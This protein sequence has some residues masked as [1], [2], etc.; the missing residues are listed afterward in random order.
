MKFDHSY[1]VIPLK[2]IGGEWITLLIKHRRSAFWGFPKGHSDEG[3]TPYQAAV[4][5]LS[6]ETGL[7]V[8]K[9]IIQEPLLERY[10]FR[11]QGKMISKTVTYFIAEVNEG[12]VTLQTEEVEDFR[13]VPLVSAENEVTY[14]QAKSLCRKTCQQILMSHN[15]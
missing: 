15:G 11:S 6:E 1:G 8:K 2:K 3:E 12:E 13:W 4:R 10:H 9:I 14:D 5:E 7:S